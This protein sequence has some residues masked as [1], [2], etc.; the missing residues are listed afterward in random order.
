MGFSFLDISGPWGTYSHSQD[1]D[2]FKEE[3]IEGVC[4]KAGPKIRGVEV[5]LNPV[6]NKASPSLSSAFQHE[7]HTCSAAIQ[8]N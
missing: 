6:G 5:R 4:Q 8:S 3:L 7:R 1:S 2:L